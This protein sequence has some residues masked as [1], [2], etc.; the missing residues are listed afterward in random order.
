[1]EGGYHAVKHVPYQPHILNDWAESHL[2]SSGEWD[3]PTRRILPK[4]ASSGYFKDMRTV[5]L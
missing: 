5:L 3:K 2:R 4:Y 1:M